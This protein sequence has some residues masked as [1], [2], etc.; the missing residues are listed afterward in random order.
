MDRK[1]KTVALNPRAV[2]AID[3]HIGE[4]IR[5]RRIEL[6]LS[7]GQ[8]AAT[9]GVTFQQVQKYERG[10]NRVSAATLLRICTALD[11]RVATFLPNWASKA[12]GGESPG[13]PVLEEL[14]QLAP[15]LNSEAR[16]KLLDFAKTLVRPTRAR[17]GS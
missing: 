13:D 4:R 1:T 17:K 15:K 3:R 10:V 8:L 14:A 11:A 2:S 5:T 9:I 16:K 6:D 7:Q 12:P